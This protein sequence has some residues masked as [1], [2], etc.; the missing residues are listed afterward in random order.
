LAENFS[1]C[2]HC[3]PVHPEL[4]KVV[5]AY[6]DAGAWGLRGAPETKPEY[7]AGAVTLTL[8][9]SAR[10]P[11]LRGLNEEERKTVYVPAMA[12]PNLFLNVHPDYVN[13]HMMFPTGPQSVRMVYDWL[14]EA[15]RL[16]MAEGDLEHYVALW[17]VTNRQDARNC[18]WQQAGVQ[19]REFRHGVFVPQEFDCHRFAQWVRG[20]LAEAPGGGDSGSR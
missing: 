18:E 13:S 10:I 11:P 14:F 7:K 3:P 19:S 2:F 5:T 4:C 8:D 6:R 17:D 9:G 15:E 1:E 20:A 16:P 12:P